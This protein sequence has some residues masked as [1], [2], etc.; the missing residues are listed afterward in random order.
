MHCNSGQ[1]AQLHTLVIDAVNNPHHNS[2]T[3]NYDARSYVHAA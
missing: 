2:C 1:R 3:H